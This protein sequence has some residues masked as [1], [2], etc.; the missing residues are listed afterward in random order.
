[1]KQLI[2]GAPPY[3][4]KDYNR[5]IH[6]RRTHDM[7]LRPLRLLLHVVDSGFNVSKAARAAHTSQPNVS[8]HL[9]ALE[10]ELGVKI[11]LRAERRI[12]GL[13]GTGQQVLE[14][15]RRIL[16]E[17]DG[18]RDLAT[19][20]PKDREGRIAIAASHTYARYSLPDVVTAFKKRYPRVRLVLRQG[21]PQ[22]IMSWTI[23]GA[24][25]LAICAALNERPKELVFF[26]CNRHDRII[27]APAGHPLCAV[28]RPTLEQLARYPLI[29]YDAQFGIHHTILESFE[30]RHLTPNIVLTAT[31]VDVMKTYVKSGLGVA[32]V[33]SLAYHRGEDRNLRAIPA[34]HLFSPTTIKLGLRK[35]GFLPSFVYDFIEMFSTNLKRQDI[36]RVLLA[37]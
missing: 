36:E 33:A 29:T 24:T 18:L 11:F 17:V 26:S 20:S 15:A 16:Y 31:D 37:R 19:V 13:T 27:L 2:I 1:M 32:I 35:G 7:Q 6:I 28:K 22:E 10:R 12:T 25:D 14:S 21:D 23:S 34:S 9:Q 3:T 4:R 8:R 5:I 30:S